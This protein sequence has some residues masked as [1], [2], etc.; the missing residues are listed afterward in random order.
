[1][2]TKQ[3]IVF[4]SIVSVLI[5]FF[6]L[7]LCVV[8]AES[9]NL[10]ECKQELDYSEYWNNYHIELNKLFEYNFC[11]YMGYS[12]GKVYHSGLEQ[13]IECFSNNKSQI[14]EFVYFDGEGSQ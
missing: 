2:N 9:N 4:I 8:I 14:F 3:K 10:S 7:I 6:S 12:Y 5:L 1:M 13:G 11:N